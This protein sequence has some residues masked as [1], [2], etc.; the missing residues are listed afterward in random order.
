LLELLMML[1]MMH[2]VVEFS[3]TETGRSF[4]KMRVIERMLTSGLLIHQDAAEFH[5]HHG[6]H[7]KRSLFYGKRLTT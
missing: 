1:K 7:H 6:L 4:D 5:R 2:V 3:P